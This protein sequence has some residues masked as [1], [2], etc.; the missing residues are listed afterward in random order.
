M[1]WFLRIVGTV[2]IS[3]AFVQA[4]FIEHHAIR[5]FPLPIATAMVAA[6]ATTTAFLLLVVAGFHQMAII[7]FL[8]VVAVTN[9]LLGMPAAL[10]LPCMLAIRNLWLAGDECPRKQ[11]DR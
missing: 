2:V 1:R 8:P 3:A 9:I 6:T 11:R 4:M 5:A 7:V 10:L